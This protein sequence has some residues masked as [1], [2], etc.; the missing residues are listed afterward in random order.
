MGEFAPEPNAASGTPHD[1]VATDPTAESINTDGRGGPP[2]NVPYARFKEVNDRYVP[3]RE[4]E[5]LGYDVD[6]LR[7]LA[8]WNANFTQDPVG[9]WLEI[10][11]NLEGLPP[12][13]REMVE[14]Y[15][16]DDDSDNSPSGHVDIEEEDDEEEYEDDENM[17]Q[18]ARDLQEFKVNQEERDRVQAETR[19]R[20]G[21][22]ETLNKITSGWEIG[23]AHV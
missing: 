16:S 6:S 5:R 11:Q 19:D 9:N 13:L 18:W 23:R 20:Q 10:A 22:L 15:M 7:Q 12:D 2:E 8:V 14:G 17:P 1:P 4:L 21:R 3:Y